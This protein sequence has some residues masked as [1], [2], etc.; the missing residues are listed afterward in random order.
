MFFVTYKISFRKNVRRK[1][2]VKL[3]FRSKAHRNWQVEQSR[4]AEGAIPRSLLR[5]MFPKLHL[6]FIPVI[7]AVAIR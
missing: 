2:I 5:N 7:D 4:V 3:Q 6:G 1:F